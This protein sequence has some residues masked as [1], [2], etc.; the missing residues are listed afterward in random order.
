MRFGHFPDI[1]AYCWKD[2]QDIA[3]RHKQ[4]APLRKYENHSSVRLLTAYY[5]NI[6]MHLGLAENGFFF[7]STAAHRLFPHMCVRKR[8]TENH[9]HSIKETTYYLKKREKDIISISTYFYATLLNQFC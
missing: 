5:I 8:K 9:R 7:L 1:V 3:E 6:T 2:I 4:H